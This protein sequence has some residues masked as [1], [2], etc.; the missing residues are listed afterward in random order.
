MSNLTDRR[1][2]IKTGAVAGVALAAMPTWLGATPDANAGNKVRVA[3]IGTNNRGLDHIN[4][5]SG[6]DGIDLAYVCDVEDKALAKGMK[7]AP[8]RCRARSRSR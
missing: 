8:T 5:L 4:C 1:D 2:F 3:V 6:I 7:K